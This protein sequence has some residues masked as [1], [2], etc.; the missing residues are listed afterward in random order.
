M[1]KIIM[2]ICVFVFFICSGIAVFADLGPKPTLD[3]VVKNLT[4]KTFYLDLLSKNSNL[5]YD[6]LN[7]NYPEEY[8]NLP[9]YK[10]N[11]DGWLAT[12]IR[13]WFLFGTLKTESD[14]ISDTTHDFTYYGVP[15][16]FKV[17]IQLESGELYVSTKEYEFTEFNQVT[18]IDFNKDMA[19]VISPD[20]TT[21][22]LTGFIKSELCPSEV[23]ES[24]LNKDFY[25]TVD[26]LYTYAAT[27]KT[28]RF[29]VN[30][31]KSLSGYK[32]QIK[33]QGYLKRVV[34]IMQATESSNI[35]KSYNAIEM[36]AGDT[37]KKTSQ[38]YEQDDSINMSDIVNL[39][40][41]FNKTSND[42]GYISQNDF[43]QD[44]VIN[45]ADVLIIAKHFVSTYPD[46][47][48][49]PYDSVTIS[50]VLVRNSFEGG[51]YGL[52]TED[53]KKYDLGAGL[54]GID[55]YLNQLVI[56]TGNAQEGVASTHM[57]GTVFNMKS[58]K[59]ENVF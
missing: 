25:V 49:S 15:K 48:I 50:G 56:V 52:I 46:L 57:W 12:N 4:A 17:I 11:D 23:T 8:K 6:K 29:E 28:G 42:S 18:T 38:G 58:I 13:D 51:F 7:S 22:K 20:E 59:P 53:N 2:S 21:V 41:S 55:Q 34:K 24:D 35:N 33:K 54:P 43:N 31:P 1:K 32:L 39:A 10:Y 16:I 36:W 27:D 47:T 14:G 37:I 9:I 45:M 44:G 26:G 3:I 19:K 40:I 30:V 5:T